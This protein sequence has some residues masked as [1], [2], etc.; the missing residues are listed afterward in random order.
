MRFLNEQPP[1]EE[2][3]LAPWR[4]TTFNVPGEKTFNANVGMYYDWQDIRGY[5]SIIPR[6]YAELMERIAPQAN[7]LLYNR[8]APLYAQQGGD[9]YAPLDNPLLDLLNV[10]YVLTEHYIP[11]PTWQEIYRDEAVGVYENRDVLPRAFIV[12]EARRRPGGRTAAA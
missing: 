4:F 10:H 8:I 9:V 12:P 3:G 7:E 11:N 5:D 2:D 6:Q 1:R